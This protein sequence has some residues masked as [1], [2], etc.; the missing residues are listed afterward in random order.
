MYEL[1]NYKNLAGGTTQALA[2]CFSVN[3]LSDSSNCF[4]AA[5]NPS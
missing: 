3:V 4:T 5:L 2:K 1:T